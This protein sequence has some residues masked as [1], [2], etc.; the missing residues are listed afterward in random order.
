[1]QEKNNRAGLYSVSRIADGLAEFLF[2]EQV[3]GTTGID[4]HIEVNRPYQRSSRVLGVKVF[5]VDTDDD[6]DMYVCSG[7]K[8]ILIYWLQHSIPILIMVY[9]SSIG[10]VFWEHLREDN[11]ILSEVGWSI[12]VPKTQEFNEEAVRS[13]YEIPSYSPNLSRLAVDRP[14]MDMIGSG[15]YRIFITTEENINRPSRKGNLKI[16]ITNSDGEKQ[17]IY[18]WPFFINPDMP[19]VYRF[20]ELFPW[21]EINVDQDFYN[22]HA[23]SET[24]FGVTLCNIRPWTIEAGEIAHFR[25]EMRLNE[26]GK[27]YLCADRFICNA[28]YDENKLEGSFGQMYEGGLKFIVTR[29]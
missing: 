26:L 20:N 11:I 2:R 16:S 22:I 25:L 10:K 9:D 23:D 18:D 7:S 27:S 1:L 3:S 24:N 17:N 15:N 4:G 8:D 29:T 6:K 19:F 21:A 12:N 5:S 13:I 14:W 28:D